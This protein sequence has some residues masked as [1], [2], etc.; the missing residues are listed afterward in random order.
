MA[1]RETFAKR[2]GPAG[3]CGITL[4]QWLRLLYDNRF[5]V[6]F[7]YWLRAGSITWGS[8][9][10]SFFA[11]LDRW[12]YEAAVRHTQ[13]ETPLF[14]LGVWRSGTT[15]LHNLLARDPRFAFPNNYQVLYPLTFLTSEAFTAPFLSHIIPRRRAQDNVR[16]ALDEPQEDEFALAAL[17]FQS[18]VMSWTFPRR[19]GYYDRF[20]TLRDCTPEELARWKEAL[21]YF[22]QKV[23]YKYGRP[24]VLKSPPHT[25]RIKLL[26]E[27]FPDAKFVHIHRNPY[28]VFR[29]SVHAF[30]KIAP[31]WT[32]QRPNLAGLEERILRQYHEVYDAYFDERGL[33]PAGRLHDLRYESLEA[34]PIGELQRLYA[35]LGLPDFAPAE[36]AIRSY[37]ESIADYAKNRPAEVPPPWKD[38]VARRWRRSFDEWRYPI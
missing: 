32:L 3:L 4:G 21:R 11:C 24:L 13:P 8:F 29:S 30:T 5:A 6:D 31:W 9:Q 2:V 12:R 16:I 19:A 20:L 10:N 23:A 25:G 36:P 17:T 33:I 1:W 7:P 15:H 22:V 35:A 14:V 37:L 38:Q 28:D 18:V 26:L 34:D 27:L